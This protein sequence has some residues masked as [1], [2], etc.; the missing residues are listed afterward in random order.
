MFLLAAFFPAF[1]AVIGYIVG[2][3]LT[4]IVQLGV[5]VGGIIYLNKQKTFREIEVMFPAWAF[6]WLC[7]GMLIG[8]LA[9]AIMHPDQV[10]AGW[11]GK[12]IGFLLV[13]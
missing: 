9:F 7:V 1:F 4:L 13:P 12:T 8:N 6:V 2:A 10:G 3:K 5:F 11:L